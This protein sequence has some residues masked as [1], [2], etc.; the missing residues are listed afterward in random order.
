MACLH[1]CSAVIGLY[2]GNLTITND[3]VCL[4]AV[5]SISTSV[6]FLSEWLLVKPF[7]VREVW[8]NIDFAKLF[9][10]SFTKEFCPE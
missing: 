6:Q 10:F 4:V 2:S 1:V 9:I 5:I 3:Q 8:C 7:L